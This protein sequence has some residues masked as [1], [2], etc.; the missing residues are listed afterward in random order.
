[1]QL[2]PSNRRKTDRNLARNG[3]MKEQAVT[4]GVVDELLPLKGHGVGVPCGCA[5]PSD[6]RQLGRSR[7]WGKD[8]EGAV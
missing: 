5:W 7:D 6:C 2:N 8:G 3:G 4:V 1:M